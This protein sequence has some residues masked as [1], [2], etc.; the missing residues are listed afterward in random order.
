MPGLKEL[1]NSYLVGSSQT[2]SVALGLVG[3]SPPGRPARMVVL[4]FM[5]TPWRLVTRQRAACR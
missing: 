1:R 3:M 5:V 2:T 4:V